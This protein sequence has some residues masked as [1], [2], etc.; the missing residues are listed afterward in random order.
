LHWSRRESGSDEL[1]VG[2]T[3]HRHRLGTHL[4]RFRESRSLRLEDV[5][6]ELGVAPST[7]SRIE[8][9]KSPTRTSYLYVMLDLYGIHNATAKR[10]L[11]ELAREGQRNGWWASQDALLPTG[12]GSYLG[13]EQAAHHISS[14]TNY[15]VPGLLQTPDYAAAAWRAT[16]P[17]LSPDNVEALVSVTLRQQ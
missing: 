2:P 10:H 8:T 14:C 13:M 17:G 15:L 1:L 4:R 5:A 11:A 3:I 12:M 9:G 7:L 6:R 16:G